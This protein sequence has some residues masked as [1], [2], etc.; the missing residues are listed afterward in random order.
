ME[1]YTGI[2]T[3]FTHRNEENG[4]TVARLS[5][6]EKNDIK[7]IGYFPVLAVGETVTVYGEFET[8]PEHGKQFSVSKYKA[9][10]PVTEKGLKHYLASGPFKGIGKKMANRLVDHF[11]VD[12]LEVIEN[13]P[14]RLSE[15]PGI[16][17]SKVEGIIKGLEAAEDHEAM[18][19]L[20]GLGLTPGYAGRVIDHYGDETVNKIKSNPYL[21]ADE[22]HGIGFKTADRL[23]IANGLE[24]DHPERITAGIKYVLEKSLE[25]GHCYLPLNE[26]LDRTSEALNV[27]EQLVIN[28]LS[29]LIKSKELI[30]EKSNEEIRIYLAVYYYAER[31]VANSLHKLKNW[32]A[33]ILVDFDYEIAQFEKRNGFKLANKQKQA[34]K[35][36]LK[37]GVSVIT[38]GPG[39]G[40]TTI[41]KCI[42]ELFEKANKRVSLAAPTGR[43]AQ[44]LSE[45][46]QRSAKTIHRLLE[47]SYTQ[48][49]MQFAKNTEN[50]LSCDV[51][52]VDEVSMV[53]I[54]LMHQL[55]QAV[56]PGCQVILVG[57]IDQLPSVGSGNV[58]WDIIDSKMISVV[59]LDEIFRQGKGSLITYNAHRINKGEFPYLD[60]SSEDFFFVDKEDPEEVVKTILSL[61]KRRLPRYKNIHPIE[62]I[63]VLS[64]MRRT[65]TGV[66]NLNIMLQKTLNP[67]RDK[68][69]KINKGKQVWYEGDKVMQI[70]NNYNKNIYNGD[71]GRIVSIDKNNK[72]LVVAYPY[73][74]KKRYVEYTFNELNELTLA[75]AISVHKSQGSEYSVV[76][77]PITTQHYL[78]LQQNLIYTGIT[79][80]KKM[81]VLVGT[82][83]AL[84][85]AI[86]NNKVEE[87]HTALSERLKELEG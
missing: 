15:V 35:M 60:N 10:I 45:S 46:A 6:D 67:K 69:P 23:A 17:K 61:C 14:E 34:I 57:D 51:L 22:V 8:H 84:A 19:F 65:T 4:Y 2:I 82:K 27:D 62:D 80:A 7:I 55:L 11:G 12:I 29:T 56:P 32:Q 70:R 53:D 33:L 21:L 59:K 37:N 43:A 58:L 86:K 20:Q 5:I 54:M 75:Y 68:E 36:G 40:K 72:E 44:K 41:I 9:E 1:Q 79:R 66:D 25:E 39:T 24:K 16:G 81:V 18:I 87:R 85:I 26:L 76:V 50:P 71:L 63:Q 47:Y 78:M 64:P 83:K 42:I 73:L 3:R 49:S 31:A 74:D 30:K 28:Q 52:I 13:H 38:G 48:G 77:M